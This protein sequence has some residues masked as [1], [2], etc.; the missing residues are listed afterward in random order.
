MFLILLFILIYI[1]VINFQKRF[2]R[3]KRLVDEESDQEEQDDGLNRE[4]IADQLF[5]GSD[6]VI[7]RGVLEF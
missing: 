2:K 5:V 1:F 4:V 7:I 6:E 3:L